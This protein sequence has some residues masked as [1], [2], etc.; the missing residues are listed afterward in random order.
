MKI[1]LICGSLRKQSLNKKL[2][3][4]LIELLKPA[5]EVR[6]MDLAS[7]S[8]PVFNE[9]IEEQYKSKLEKH[10]SSYAD[11]QLWLIVSPEYNGSISCVL[12]NDLDWISRANLKFFEKKNVML[13]SASPG[14]LGGLRGLWHAR[15]TLDVLNAYTHPTMIAVS[16]AHERVQE[17][18]F[19]LS[20]K[21]QKIVNEVVHD[22]QL[23]IG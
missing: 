14:Q 15:H 12:K 10:L 11:T 6:W 8:L 20:E 16:K 4:A 2:C 5:H 1:S 21:E 23:R 9:D 18:R 7:L 13:L 3:A 19:Q 17:D 22:I